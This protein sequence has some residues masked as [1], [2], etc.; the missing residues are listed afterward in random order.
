MKDGIGIEMI[1][2]HDVLVAAKGAEGGAASFVSVQ[3][4]DWFD[5]DVD[6]IGIDSRKGV[7]RGGGWDRSILG[8]ADVLP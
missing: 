2:H 5:S 4:V 1:G 7:K 8:G 6:F 3:F